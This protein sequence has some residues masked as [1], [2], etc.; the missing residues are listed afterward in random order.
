ML[1]TN[2]YV[3]NNNTHTFPTIEKEMKEL[4]NNTPVVIIETPFGNV[5]YQE[6]WNLNKGSLLQLLACYYQRVSDQKAEI[7]NTWQE[8]VY[9]LRDSGFKM[10][11]D[12]IADPAF[13]ND[14]ITITLC[15]FENINFGLNVFVVP[16]GVKHNLRYNNANIRDILLHLVQRCRYITSCNIPTRYANDA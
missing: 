8:H 7:G 11:T 14:V 6:S 15:G 16:H 12:L 1:N 13:E 4:K 3:E 9:P 5:K 10:Y 2:Q